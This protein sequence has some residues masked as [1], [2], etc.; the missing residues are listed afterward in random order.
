MVKAE[1]IK[2]LMT[3]NLP[4]LAKTTAVRYFPQK[5]DGKKKPTGIK[6]YLATINITDKCN[7]R[8]VK[9]N[10]WRE[11][12]PGEF[13]KDDWMGVMK[14]LADIGIKDINFTGGEPMMVKGIID[15]MRRATELGITVGMT[16]NGY[17]LNE[18]KIRQLLDAGLKTVTLSVDAL[19]DA[20]DEIRGYDGSFQKLEENLSIL[21]RYRKE[22]KI[23]VY[24]AFLLMKD[25]LAHY[26]GV[27]EFAKG[28][29]IPVVVNLFDS[30]PYFFQL[31]KGTPS[32]DEDGWIKKDVDRSRLREFQRYMIEEK[33]KNP[34]FS[35][36]SFSE[37][38][39]MGEYFN[40]PLRQ[41]MP[42][43]VS[44]KRICIGP[45]GQVYGGCWSMGTFGDLHTQTL[46]EVLE[47]EYYVK[48]H[49]RMFEK[50]CP[51]CTC[52]YSTNVRYSLPDVVNEMKY[53]TLPS[54]RKEIY[55]SS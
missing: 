7:L 34:D 30:T 40:D 33:S 17:L 2:R 41:D 16:S 39:Y 18:E 36:H 25:T 15:I 43:A 14:Q 52:G 13:V 21:S 23:N 44:Q 48:T 26:K 10:Q 45:K 3:V 32:E 35:Y 38:K 6:P 50:K 47:S 49:R 19:G 11:P 8:C 24:I 53:R 55:Q 54:T 46:K 51:G 31:G 28:L 1:K 4:V 20:H 42:C 5:E 12:H 37:I 22:G 9:C 29:G 27:M